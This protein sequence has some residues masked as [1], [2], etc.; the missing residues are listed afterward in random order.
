MSE[1]EKSFTTEKYVV[2]YPVHTEEDNLRLDQFVQK[3][4]PTLSRQFLKRKIDK[5]EV[6]ISG[7]K[8]P[9]KP[10]VKV[11]A[12][13][14]VTVTTHND[15][16][17]EEEYWYGVPVPK[18]QE[19]QIIFEDA[20]LLVINK[21]PF[22]ITH[23]AGK[24]LFYCA[25]VFFET[26]YKHRMHS[27]HRLDRETSGILLLGKNPQVSQKVS[28][29]FEEDK[30][31]KCYFLIAHKEP[32]AEPVPF[33][34]RQRL[35]RDESATPRGMITS[36][37]EDSTEGKDSET[38][39]ELLLEKNGY[40]LLLAYPLSGR[41][42]QIRVH[43]ACN[44]YPLL[45]DKLYNGDSGVFLRF[46]DFVPTEEDHQKMQIPRQALHAVAI[47]LTYPHESMTHFL[48][49]LPQDLSSWL[50][51]KLLIPKGHVEKLIEE[52]VLAWLR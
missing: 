50:G 11:H 18:D 31:K 46:K 22:M 20:G 27:I 6:V 43:A 9:H 45:G 35:G 3:N 44:G 38:H 23:P 34:A 47:K 26:V 5:G 33:T 8:P 21:P 19:P 14:R 13:E 40:V 41:Q 16:I 17:I 52:K 51:E 15:G 4:M 36:H 1:I 25:T 49:P 37:P 28:L 2:S 7:R 29:L 48:A 42:H 24:N 32:G 10:S 30:V 12:G 39:F